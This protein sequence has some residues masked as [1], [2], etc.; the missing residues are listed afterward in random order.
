MDDKPFSS[1]RWTTEVTTNESE[2]SSWFMYELV[3][4]ILRS[5][6]QPEPETS[7]GDFKVMQNE[8][9]PYSVY[10]ALL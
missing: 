6:R 9:I 4:N 8:Q 3:L 5:P 10:T 1:F 2:Q 7:T